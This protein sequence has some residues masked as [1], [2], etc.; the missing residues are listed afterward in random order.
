MLGQGLELIGVMMVDSLYLALEDVAQGHFLAVGILAELGVEL[1]LDDIQRSGGDGG[2]SARYSSAQVELQPVII[3]LGADHVLQLL[4]ED[5]DQGPK[6]N[7]HRVIHREASVEGYQPLLLQN[8]PAES[9]HFHACILGPCQLQ[10][11]LEG[12]SWGH[13]QVVKH[14][15]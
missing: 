6:G 11:L 15:R 4:V 7:V 9:H 10:S 5:H 13:Q 3:F 8:L 1:G 2:D 12:L 14:G